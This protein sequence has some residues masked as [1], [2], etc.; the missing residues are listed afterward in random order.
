LAQV[1]QPGDV[2]GGRFELHGVV[3]R[4]GTAEVW[5]ATDRL[6]EERVALKI[7]HSHLASDPDVRRR[8]QREVGTAALLRS[9]AALVPYDLHEV[10]GV[11]AL[12]MPFHP[13]QTLTERV[14]ARGRLTA[15]QVRS[16]G[17]RLATALADAHRAGVLHRDVTANNVL[18]GERIEESVLT[19]F[20]LSRVLGTTRSTGLLGTAGYAA[21]EVYAG[22][23]ADPRSDLYGL[24]GVLYLALTGRPAFDPKD[25]MSALKR[26]LDES[27]TPVRELAPDCPKDLAEL[28]EQLLRADPA[29][30]PQGARDVLDALVRREAPAIEVRTTPTAEP[31]PAAR[32][33]PDGAYTVLVKE[34]HDDRQRRDRLRRQSLGVRPRPEDELAR[35]GQQ[36]VG[37]IRDAI[38]LPAAGQLT[39][40]MGLHAA[41]VE[42]VGT[43]QVHP[44]QVV[45]EQRFRLVDHTD[46]DTAPH[47]ANRAS[48]LGF[49]AEVV[50][51]SERSRSWRL[52]RAALITLMVVGW[53]GIVQLMEWVGPLALVG[54]IGLSVAIGQLTSRQGVISE[55]E[56]RRY[57][58][59][60][61][62]SLAGLLPVG[63][64]AAAPPARP[65]PEPVPEAPPSRGAQLRARAM[66]AIDALERAAADAELPDLARSDL[67]AS[68]ARMR[69]R[70]DELAADVDRIEQA[71]GNIGDEADVTA[72]R[73]RLERMAALER[74]GERVDARERDRVQ[75]AIAAHEAD[76]DAADRLDSEL[77][78]AT[79]GL[80]E[81]ASGAS[82]I[83]R[84]LAL[85]RD[86]H[87]SADELVARLTRDAKAAVDARREAGMR[88]QLAARAVER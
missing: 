6:R 36:I 86:P 3:G 30:R 18:V 59:A 55:R 48:T 46:L 78:A 71:T 63:V 7:V 88:A 2:L 37:K 51:V 29:R 50:E 87:A 22:E 26:Q 62:R 16:L 81:L 34:R 39:P 14:A 38:G 79:A 12:S 44:T 64:L 60:Y 42:L 13:G 74:A 58:V 66:S 1:R 49:R 43:D 19:D 8:L 17:I 53:V 25:P 5:L 61:P 68:V 15:E 4:G 21:P 32:P 69:A 76:R 54:M 77:A 27:H 80:L 28:V 84:E 57:P 65:E 52:V 23:R 83:R 73:T 31:A 45:L 35:F 47:L 75:Q 72:L 82:R 10:D 24:G 85:D 9:P 20:G 11:F 56:L 70:A 41:I 67:R 33:L 40:E